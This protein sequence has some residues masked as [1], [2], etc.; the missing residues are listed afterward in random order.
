MNLSPAGNGSGVGYAM[1][2]ASDAE[3]QPPKRDLQRCG[4]RQPACRALIDASYGI[5]GLIAVAV[6]SELGDCRRFSRSEQVVR[7]TGLDVTV[8][9]SVLTSL[10]LHLD[11]HL[12]P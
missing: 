6:R 8:G 5:G 4:H 1:L 7:H 10:W 3:A 12:W 2:D 11:E 9:A